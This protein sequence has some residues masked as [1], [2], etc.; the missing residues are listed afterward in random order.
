[1]KSRIRRRQLER[2]QAQRADNTELET[3]LGSALGVADGV[4]H[5]AQAPQAAESAGEDGVLEARDEHGTDGGGE[6]FGEVG[7]G[8]LG[9]FVRRLDVSMDCKRYVGFSSGRE[10]RE[11]RE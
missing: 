11:G 9:F 3:S 4:E 2:E 8:A 5:P 10:G 6:V 7:V 1:M